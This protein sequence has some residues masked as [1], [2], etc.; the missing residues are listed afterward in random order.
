MQKQNNEKKIKI[1]W[2]C[3]ELTKSA[4]DSAPPRSG[5]GRRAPAEDPLVGSPGA[6]TVEVTAPA[7]VAG[8]AL[9]LEVPEVAAVEVPAG[10]STFSRAS[11]S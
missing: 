3:C 2:R 5:A 7:G 6:A 4:S 10:S 8:V 11:F 9:V 1:T